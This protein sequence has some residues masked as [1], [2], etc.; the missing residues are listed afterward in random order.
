MVKVCI[1]GA[2]QDVNP[3][4]VD[5]DATQDDVDLGGDDTPKDDDDDVNLD[6]SDEGVTE[7]DISVNLI[8][9]IPL[10]RHSESAPNR[11]AHSPFLVYFSHGVVRRNI[12]TQYI[13]VCLT[14]ITTLMHRKARGRRRL[15]KVMHKEPCEGFEL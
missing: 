5:D 9:T 8:H 14:I 12:R 13:N 1:N 7:D 10:L 6:V 2:V 11:T 4:L 15:A 3:N